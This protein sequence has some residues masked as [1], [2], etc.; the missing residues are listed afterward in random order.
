MPSI[1][2]SGAAVHPPSH[3]AGETIHKDAQRSQSHS[4]TASTAY[5]HHPPHVYKTKKPSTLSPLHH[6]FITPSPYSKPLSPTTNRSKNALP[7]PPPPH[8]RPLH[9]HRL[10]RRN[11]LPIRPRPNL[12]R[13]VLRLPPLANPR[14]VPDP[15]VRRKRHSV[16]CPSVP[17]GMGCVY[18]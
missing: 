17:G 1:Q 3:G 8:P 10:R 11:N 4:H 12:A 2:H 7:H 6:P 16:Y 14:P 15:R 18:R 9:H 5:N 13:R